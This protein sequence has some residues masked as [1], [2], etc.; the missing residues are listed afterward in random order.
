M[1]TEKTGY[2][3][4]G[5]VWGSNAAAMGVQVLQQFP[6]CCGMQTLSGFDAFNSMANLKLAIDPFKKWIARFECYGIMAVLSEEE[7]ADA[8]FKLL[9]EAGFRQTAK[10][11]NIN[12]GSMLHVYFLEPQREYEEEE[13]EDDGDW[14]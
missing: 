1:S 6:H 14:Y 3:G 9:K 11:K 8:W 13:G 4:L 2:E 10:F 7:S 12:T 5:Y